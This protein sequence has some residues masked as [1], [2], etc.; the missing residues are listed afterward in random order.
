VEEV[1]G[2]VIQALGLSA[3]SRKYFMATGRKRRSSTG[4]HGHGPTSNGS[5]SS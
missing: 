2:H 3:N 4:S 1:N 5:G